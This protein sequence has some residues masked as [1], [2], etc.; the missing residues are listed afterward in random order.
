MRQCWKGDLENN[1]LMRQCWKGDLEN[2]KL[3]ILG[4]NQGNVKDK[5][6]TIKKENCSRTIA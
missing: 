3:V 6:I 4:G 5:E 1:K 2:I